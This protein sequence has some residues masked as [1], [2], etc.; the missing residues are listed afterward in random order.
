Q[1]SVIGS[2]PREPADGA[3]GV[4]H[5]RS[6]AA[7]AV[8]GPRSFPTIRALPSGE[9]Q[10]PD[11]YHRGA[12]HVHHV[13]YPLHGAPPV[14]WSLSTVGRSPVLKLKGDCPFRRLAWS[15]KSSV[16]LSARPY[17]KSPA[18]ATWTSP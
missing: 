9:H 18:R 6:E 3:P 4:R 16:A 5:R 14:S 7:C 10:R 11:G 2:V 15:S 8:L 12:P 13:G 1:A 17:G